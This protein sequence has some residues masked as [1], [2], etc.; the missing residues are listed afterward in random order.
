M[1]PSH[2]GLWCWSVSEP[3]DNGNVHYVK[4]MG[5]YYVSTETNYMHKVDPETLASMEKVLGYCYNSEV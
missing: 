3:T 1:K 4:Y 2:G 5:D